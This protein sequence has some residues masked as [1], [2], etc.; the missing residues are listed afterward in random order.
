MDTRTKHRWLSVERATNSLGQISIAPL[1]GLCDKKP[2][3]NSPE[4][5]TVSRKK[6]LYFDII[7]QTQIQTSDHRQ[8][9]LSSVRNKD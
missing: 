1:N 2:Y 8:A 3:K 5:Q 6:M 7:V 9:L 4:N